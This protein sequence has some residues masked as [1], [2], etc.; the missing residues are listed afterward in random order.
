MSEPHHGTDPRP[1]LV[2]DDDVDIREAL[3]DVLAQRGYAVLTAVNGADALRV[4]RE[5][6]VQPSVI[7]LDLMM[8]V[9]DGYGFLAQQR[10]DPLLA[11][12]QVALITAGHGIDRALLGEGTPVIPK[13]F[14]FANLMATIERLRLAEPAA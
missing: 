1:I 13:P 8:P 10:A 6:P 11:K 9:L 5:A 14:N 7:L 2:V 12:L 3:A 4:L